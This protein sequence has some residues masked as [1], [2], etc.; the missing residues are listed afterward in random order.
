[1]ISRELILKQ[2]AQ[3]I[4]IPLESIYSAR[5]NLKIIT[6]FK[7]DIFVNTGEYSDEVGLLIEG[8][9][10]KFSLS[11]EGQETTTDL[12][13]PGNFA[14]SYADQLSNIPSQHTIE[15]L[16]KTTVAVLSFAELRELV[17]NDPAWTMAGLKIAESLYLK[18]ADRELVLMTM[19]AKERLEHF[20][21]KNPIKWRLVPKNVIASFLGINPST[22]SRIISKN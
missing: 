11:N 1:M 3:K 8:I 9:L 20:I 10:R 21:Q 15:A 16:E 18:K 4:E 2:L 17:I 6:L 14:A 19:S 5:L 12:V 13:F 22:L 7:G